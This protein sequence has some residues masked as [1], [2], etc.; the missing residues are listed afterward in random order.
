MCQRLEI[1]R[2]AIACHLRF[3]TLWVEC[4]PE[5]SLRQKHQH[6]HK[7]CIY[8]NVSLSWSLH[9]LSFP[10]NTR[11]YDLLPLQFLSRLIINFNVGVTARRKLSWLCQV[12]PPLGQHIQGTPGPHWQH[13]CHKAALYV[14]PSPTRG[15]AGVLP[16]VFTVGT[17]LV[18][19]KY[20]HWSKACRPTVITGRSW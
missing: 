17:R 12:A 20:P 14:P 10:P 16:L 19:N 9:F 6:A 2:K 13:T 18:S 4:F 1:P 3:F 7:P 8:H 15:P 11:L 5:K